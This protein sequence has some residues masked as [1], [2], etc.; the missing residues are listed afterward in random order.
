MNNHRVIAVC[1]KGGVGKTAFTTLLTK[2]M[3][4]DPQ[5]GKL[6]LVDADPAL[7]LH[8]ALGRKE[9]KTIGTVRDEILRVAEEGDRQAQEELADKVDDLTARVWDEGKDFAFLA[10]CYRESKDCFC[11]VID[12]LQQAISFLTNEFTTALIN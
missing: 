2:V 10:L 6:L 8:Y 11:S 3:I 4:E 1:G 5:A 12:L 7:G 9:I